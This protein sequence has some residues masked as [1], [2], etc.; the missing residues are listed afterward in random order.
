[1]KWNWGNALL[2]F[3]TVYISFLVFVVVKSK[4]VDHGLV[5][6]D[7][8]DHD[9]AYQKRYD[10]L[11]NRKYLDKDL[12][13]SYLIDKS[14]VQLDF[15]KAQP[16]ISG[17]VVFYRP[18]NSNQDIEQSFEHRT[19]ENVLLD[20]KDLDYGLWTIK[21]TWSDQTRIYYK[22]EKIYIPQT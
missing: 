6:E 22:E 13:I 8:Y 15:G 16:P 11:T 21:V 12:T 5:M 9:L 4:S 20:A 2:L 1:M 19:T 17:N 10:E 18:S 14:A 3:F 7:Y